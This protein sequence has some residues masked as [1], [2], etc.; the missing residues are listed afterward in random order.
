MVL[1]VG[2][3]WIVLQRM[4]MSWFGAAAGA[5][6]FIG[7]LPAYRNWVQMLGEPQALAA[8]MLALLVALGYQ[9][10]RRWGWRAATIVVLLAF[11]MFSKE[12]VGVL[13]VP[14]VLLAC[15]WKAD[16]SLGRPALNRRNLVLSTLVAVLV[17]AVLALLAYVRTRP[18]A[19]GYGMAYGGGELSLSRLAQNLGATV[20]PSWRAGDDPVRLFYPA[21]LLFILLV[22]LAWIPRLLSATSRSTA[23]RL[24]GWALLFPLLGVLAYLP[25]PKFDSFYALLFFFGSAV[26]LAQAVTWLERQSSKHAIAAR[27]AVVLIMVY[28][29]LSTQRSTATSLAALRLNVAL[30]QRLPSLAGHDSVV[31]VGPRSGPRRLPVLAA[32]LRGYAV[33]M[34]YGTEQQM[35]RMRDL[36]CADGQTVL[37]ETQ[38]R[39]VLMTY[40]YGCGS[41]PRPTMRLRTEFH[42]RDWVTLAPVRDSFAIDLMVPR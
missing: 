24:L 9:A 27:G 13:A 37:R 21:N 19:V 30:A 17:L 32:E 40:S 12:V 39:V 2:L 34:R 1:D 3:V 31:I 36:E 10:S 22:A 15:C 11:V 38:A 8:L 7:G 5:G 25:W 18:Q 4:G 35:P 23:Q 42:Y 14:V 29:A 26:L 41:L 20:L 28:L 6:L 16:G 33:A